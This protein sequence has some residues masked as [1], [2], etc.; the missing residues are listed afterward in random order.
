MSS[1][2]NEM[3]PEPTFLFQSIILMVA[4]SPAVTPCYGGTRHHISYA[5]GVPG[6]NVV[7]VLQEL[8]LRE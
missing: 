3:H 5:H 2:K 1:G 8:N 6:R 7:L 4:L